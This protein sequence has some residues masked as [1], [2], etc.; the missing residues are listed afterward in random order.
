MSH[1]GACA[2]DPE[3]DG[4]YIRRS[5]TASLASLA[6]LTKPATE[7]TMRYRD[8]GMAEANPELF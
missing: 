8:Q 7:N 3:S 1:K 5:S 4:E 6:K 2:A